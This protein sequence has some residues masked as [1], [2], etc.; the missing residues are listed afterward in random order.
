MR[1]LLSLRALRLSCRTK[2]RRCY[3]KAS[4][5]QQSRR[6]FSGEFEGS[7]LKYEELT[8]FLARVVTW[9]TG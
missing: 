2:F 8:V 1:V 4:Y 9:A 6:L 3:R 7:A 5:A